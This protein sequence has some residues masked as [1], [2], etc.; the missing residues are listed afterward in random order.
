M[1]TKIKSLFLN[2]P[3]RFI[4]V[5]YFLIILFVW[6]YSSLGYDGI[7]KPLDTFNKEQAVGISSIFLGVLVDIFVIPIYEEI[8]FRSWL[9]SKLSTFWQKVAFAGFWIF[10][11][12]YILSNFFKIFP[13]AESLQEFFGNIFRLI[14]EIPILSPIT[15]LLKVFLAVGFVVL[16]GLSINRFWHTKFLKSLFSNNVRQTYWIIASATIFILAHYSISFFEKSVDLGW[17]N[18][19]G[20]FVLGISR[21]FHSIIHYYYG[22]KTSIIFHIFNNYSATYVAVIAVPK[23]YYWTFNTLYTVGF[24]LLLNLLLKYA[25]ENKMLTQLDLGE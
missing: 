2:N 3:L 13:V 21:L 15:E 24:I 10:F 6:T 14:F 22:I 8:I 9:K 5:Y 19:F 23:E 25:R 18:F 11:I 17:L 20:F 12:T 1:L 16:L 4:L 7:V